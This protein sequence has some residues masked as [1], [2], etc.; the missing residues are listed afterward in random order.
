MVAN[1]VGLKL[2]LVILLALSG[3]IP[4]FFMERLWV[5]GY[6]K[7]ADDQGRQPAELSLSLARMIERNLMERYGDAQAFGRNTAVFNKRT[8]YRRGSNHNEIAAA[9][10][11]YVR[12]YQSYS[13]IMAVDAHGSL[14]AVNDKDSLGNPLDTAPLYRQNFSDQAWFTAA[15][16]DNFYTAPGKLTGTAVQNVFTSEYLKTVAPANPSGIGF[17]APIIDPE[18]KRL[19]V[20][21]NIASTHLVTEI[22]D[23]FAENFSN[24]TGFRSLRVFVI[25]DDMT[26]IA[27][28]HNGADDPSLLA[29]IKGLARAGFSENGAR[30]I[31]SS[32]EEGIFVG[33]GHSDGLSDFKGMPW[34]VVTSL[35]E[36]ELMRASN[37]ARSSISIVY[38]AGGLITLVV[39]AFVLTSFV[40]P[41]ELLIGRLKRASE[42]LNGS[43]SRVSGAAGGLAE[44]AS[45]QERTV[46]DCAEMLDG[47]ASLSRQ[48]ADGSREA[49][50]RAA[51]ARTASEQSLEAMGSM[52]S[53]ISSI[54]SAADE[55]ALIVKIIDEIGFQTNLLA[56]NAAVEAARAGDSGKGFAVV[57]E[58]VR[59]LAQRSSGAARETSSKIR[60]AQTLAQ[61]GV[62]VSAEVE[63]ILTSISESSD[64]TKEFVGE[65]VQSST[66]Q[67][68][69]LCAIGDEIGTL[70]EASRTNSLLSRQA[71]ETAAAVT[72]QAETYSNIVKGL[73]GLVYRTGSKMAEN[74]PRPR[75][76]TNSRPAV[77]SREITTPMKSKAPAPHVVAKTRFL[78]RS[79][80]S[81]ESPS[82]SVDNLRDS[83]PVV[84]LKSSQ[85]IPFDDNDFQGF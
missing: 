47:I 19:G 76:T 82:I 18:G 40:H 39:V 16:S 6:R 56:L 27:T 12:L 51:G 57:A 84:E 70:R 13:L 36:D 45:G 3:L 83:V 67:S 58:E 61:G 11:R 85:I 30:R 49:L 42:A 64:K 48:N 14:I 22:V 33:Y 81:F 29:A 8:W 7:M 28:H 32:G 4:T 2:K 77:R 20:W 15:M 17:A 59:N 69:A 55:T 80:I 52:L 46:E 38:V 43:A 9:M 41:L 50:T 35:D 53:S 37:D 74:L 34:S 75:T 73:E 24:I 1:R 23:E 68:D 21:C 5:S 54:K 63:R 44:T 71:Y 25:N 26:S 65:I 72:A 78:E 60:H 62:A 66:A 10:N 79:D 31:S